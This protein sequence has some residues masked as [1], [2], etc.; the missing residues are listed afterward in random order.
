MTYTV[1]ETNFVGLNLRV[2]FNL[3]CDCVSELGNF[4]FFAL[5]SISI[6]SNIATNCCSVDRSTAL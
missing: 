2:S 4:L 1:T 3:S 5:H 6:I